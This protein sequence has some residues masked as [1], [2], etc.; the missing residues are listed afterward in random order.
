MTYAM[1]FQKYVK[2]VLRV[3]A[4]PAARQRKVKNMNLP[5]A[6]TQHHTFSPGAVY[7]IRVYTARAAVG[8]GPYGVDII[9]SP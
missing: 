9:E 7:N 4:S 1:P 5:R 6:N 8:V 3:A 2:T